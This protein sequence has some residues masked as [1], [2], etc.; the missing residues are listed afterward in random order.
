M[1]LSQHSIPPCHSLPPVCVPTGV[2]GR[3]AAHQRWLYRSFF[4]TVM[5]RWWAEVVCGMQKVRSVLVGRGQ[6][7]GPN[8][9]MS[10]GPQVVEFHCS[11]CAVCGWGGRPL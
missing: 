9:G 4:P 5:H 8:G 2:M 10:G 3:E 1:S 7:T 11:R 6:G